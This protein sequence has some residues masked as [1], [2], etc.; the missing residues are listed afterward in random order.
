MGIRRIQGAPVSLVMY[1]VSRKFI[2]V[3]VIASLLGCWGGYRLSVMMLGSIWANYVS[4]GPG[5]LL[6]SAS[7]IFFATAVTT[8]FK[9]LKAASRNPVDSLRYE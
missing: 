6:I 7:I 5:L 8:M 9:I 2:E 3:L 4:I 1:L